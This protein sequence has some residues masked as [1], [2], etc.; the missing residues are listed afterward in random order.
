MITKL[1]GLVYSDC[2][3]TPKNK[4]KL[5]ASNCESSTITS[6]FKTVI[7]ISTGLDV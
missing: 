1:C 6:S 3:L 7:T 2:E 5:I 4:S